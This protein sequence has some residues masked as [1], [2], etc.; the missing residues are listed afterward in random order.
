[1]KF[2]SH[3]LTPRQSKRY[4]K[5]LRRNERTSTLIYMTKTRTSFAS[6]HMTIFSLSWKECSRVRLDQKSK[7]PPNRSIRL[8][9]ASKTSETHP[10]FKWLKYQNLKY[11]MPTTEILSHSNLRFHKGRRLKPKRALQS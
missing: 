6:Y 9:D 2:I 7:R 8:Q 1:M 3:Q 5:W 11:L 10:K 4:S